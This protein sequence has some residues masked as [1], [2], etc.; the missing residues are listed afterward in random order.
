MIL[1]PKMR[2]ASTIGFRHPS[3]AVIERGACG[4]VV[5]IEQHAG[6]EGCP[7]VQFDSGALV[8]MKPEQLEDEPARI[9]EHVGPK[10]PGE[11]ATQRLEAALQAGKDDAER[12]AWLDEISAFAVVTIGFEIDGGI[13]L[14]I[15]SPGVEVYV[16][17]EQNDTRAAIDKARKEYNPED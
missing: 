15:E 10:S 14:N 17:R 8:W 6:I 12:I 4:H 3:G 16:A 13:F 2:V 11:L 9:F 7:L 1:Q 5:R